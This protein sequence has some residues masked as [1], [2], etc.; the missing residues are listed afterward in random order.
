ML[1]LYRDF[2]VKIRQKY[3]PDKF[4][5]INIFISVRNVD[6]IFCHVVNS[7]PF[8]CMNVIFH[9]LETSLVLLSQIYSRLNDIL[10]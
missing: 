3:F 10:R 9:V 5:K 8:H 4:L 7:F 6:Y 1:S 2:V